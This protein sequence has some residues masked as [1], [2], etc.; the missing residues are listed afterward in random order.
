VHKTFSRT[1]T[2][3]PLIVVIFRIFEKEKPSGDDNWVIK[4]WSFS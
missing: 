4:Y 2:Q 3:T 1:K